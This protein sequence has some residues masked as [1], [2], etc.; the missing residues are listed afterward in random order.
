MTARWPLWLAAAVLAIAFAASLS[1][2]ARPAL[3]RFASG[4]ADPALCDLPADLAAREAA[5]DAGREEEVRL[6]RELAAV[7]DEVLRRRALCRIPPDPPPPPPPQ[8][9]T[10]EPVPPPAPDPPRTAALPEDRWRARD[11]GMLEGCWILG[12][13]ARATL[14]TPNG[15]IPGT[16]RAGRL[17]FGANGQGTRDAR[18]EFQDGTRVN[19]RAPVTASF[20]G[21]G[22]LQTRQPQVRCNP[23]NVE[24]RAQ[25]NWLTCERRD[26]DTAICRDGEGYQH[27]F[28]RERRG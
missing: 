24:W 28:R 16:V 22:R 1:W 27:E 12:R 17:C 23:P 15:V 13:D 18:Q 9:A 5:G 14:A 20:D 8:V 7:E 19:C 3:S 2:F 25:P 21:Q 4:L 10:P 6:R 11:V 26:D